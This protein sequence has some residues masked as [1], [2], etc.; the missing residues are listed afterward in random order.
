M[1]CSA[2]YWSQ[3]LSLGGPARRVAPADIPVERSTK[4][5]L[6]VNLKKM[7]GLT[8]PTSL[9]ATAG[10][11][12]TKAFA[13]DQR[14]RARRCPLLAQSGHAN[15]AQRCLLLRVKRTL[16]GCPAMSVHDRRFAREGEG[17]FYCRTC[18]RMIVPEIEK[19]PIAT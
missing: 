13:V 10:A 4:V 1:I 15:R 16:L 3:R 6:A 12:L 2:F 17:R 11:R 19:A 5:E 8:I 14:P 18:R 9:L 7:L